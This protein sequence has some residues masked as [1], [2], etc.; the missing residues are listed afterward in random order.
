MKPVLTVSVVW[1]QTSSVNIGLTSFTFS[2]SFI[3]KNTKSSY[4]KI[5]LLNCTLFN[6]WHSWDFKQ[7]NAH[8]MHFKK[9]HCY[10]YELHNNMMSDLWLVPWYLAMPLGQESSHTEACPTVLKI[11]Y[12]LKYSIY[13]FMCWSTG[14][15]KPLFSFSSNLSELGV[16]GLFAFS[17]A[18]LKSSSHQL[19]Y[20]SLNVSENSKQSFKTALW[21]CF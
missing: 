12:L 18:A 3:K 2:V 6:S 19:N 5:N 13:F 11:L 16:I 15:P 1:I 20:Y 10:G 4:F 21:L 14:L 7:L 8:I 9:W 17:L